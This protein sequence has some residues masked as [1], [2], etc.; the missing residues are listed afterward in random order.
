MGETLKVAAKNEAIGISILVVVLCVSPIII[1]LV[2]NAAATI[3]VGQAL[4]L[5]KT[6]AHV[7]LFMC[8]R[9]YGFFN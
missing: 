6:E 3:Q 1:V 5:F 9:L 8:L 4:N 2:K 7:I